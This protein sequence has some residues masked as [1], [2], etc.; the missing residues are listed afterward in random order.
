MKTSEAVDYILKD[1][2]CLGMVRQLSPLDLLKTLAKLGIIKTKE[3]ARD[4]I[5]K[6]NEDVW[7]EPV[8]THQFAPPPKEK[9]DDWPYDAM[10][11]QFMK[12]KN[13]AK[14]GMMT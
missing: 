2:T 14:Q 8:Q 13:T 7:V 6:V 11:T 9:C 3:Q 5:L 10:T 12:R 1:E 4:I